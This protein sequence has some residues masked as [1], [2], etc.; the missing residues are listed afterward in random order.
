MSP[1]SANRPAVRL[2]RP[3]GMDDLIR[4][5]QED[6]IFL[7]TEIRPRSGAVISLLRRSSPGSD[8]EPLEYAYF[9][10]SLDIIS[11]PERF[12]L[13]LVLSP[14]LAGQRGLHRRLSRLRLGIE[15]ELYDLVLIYH[16]WYRTT[17]ANDLL[18]RAVG[19]GPGKKY[20]RINTFDNTAWFNRERFGDFIFR[21]YACA[22]VDMHAHTPKEDVS[23]KALFGEIGRWRNAEFRSGY[24]VDALLDFVAKDL[25]GSN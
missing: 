21:M 12:L 11:R 15:A 9:R 24:R 25:E 20:L 22:L 18:A 3:R 5:L 4:H 19:P 1:G 2:F 13:L 23:E 7:D 8:L 16:D 10:K 17:H 14:I 6:P